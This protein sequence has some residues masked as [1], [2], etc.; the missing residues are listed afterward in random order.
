[1]AIADTIG[2]WLPAFIAPVVLYYAR[3]VAIHK[4]WMGESPPPP[5]PTDNVNQQ[6]L[7][8][9][10]DVHGMLGEINV[11]ISEHRQVSVET[12]GHIQARLDRL[13]ELGEAR[14]RD[15]EMLIYQRVPNSH[16]SSAAAHLN[17]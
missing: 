6:I 7:D 9:L 16:V 5:P 3:K 10:R 14:E 12:F 2:V 17:G 1:M 4:G 15:S 13:T 8:V 11:N